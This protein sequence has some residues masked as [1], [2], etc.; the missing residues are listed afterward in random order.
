LRAALNYAIT[1]KTIAT[2]TAWRTA[3]RPFPDV[4]G[5]SERYL[6]LDEC[7]RLRNHADEDFRPLVTG[8]LFRGGRY[9][10]LRLLKVQ[11]I[12]FASRIALFRTT[13]SGKKQA[14]KLTA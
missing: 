2:D 1:K 14:V 10:S 5:A 3:L 6:T 12:D 4:D 9:G 7:E 13:K 8:A 11:D